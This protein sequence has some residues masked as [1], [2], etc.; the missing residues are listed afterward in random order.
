MENIIR[1]CCQSSHSECGVLVHVEDGMVTKIEGDPDHPV[2]R[3]YICVKAKAQPQLINHPD[4]LKYPM[5]QI[6]K[7]GNS[8]W[9]RISWDEALD[10]IAT[11]LTEIK[12]KNAPENIATIHGTGPRSSIPST[13]LLAHALGSPNVISTD[14]HICYAPSLVAE[15]CTVGTT[16]TMSIGPDYEY[17]NCVLVWGANPLASHGSRGRD[18]LEAKKRGAK[19]IVIDPRRTHLAKAADLWL[20]VRP[21][22]DAALAL[23]FIHTIIEEELYNTQFVDKWCYGFDKLRDHIKQYS[24]E[25]ISDIT[26]IPASKISETAR[27]YANTKPA[28]LY[29][30]VAVEHNLSSTQTNRAFCILTALTGN[31]DVKGGNIIADPIDGYIGGHALYA[32]GDSRFRLDH[33]VEEKRIGSIEYPLISGANRPGKAFT[34]VHAALAVDAMLTGNP[35]PIKALYCAGGNPIVNQQNSKKVW[36]ALKNLELL[37]VADFFMTPV[38][39]LADYVLPVTNWL[40]RDECCDSTYPNCISARQKAIEPLFECWDDLKIAIE[41]VKRIPWANKQFLPWNDVNEFNDFRIKGTGITFNEFKKKGYITGPL[42]YKKYIERGFN[43]PTKKVELFSTI[44]E[45]L[46][47]D[48]M[49]TFTEPPESPVSTPEL[50]KEYPF[51]LISGGRSIGYLHSE[52][53]QIPKLRSLVPDPLIELH[54]T[55]A[56]KAGIS[57]GCWVWVETP[58]V[59]GEKVQFKAKVTSD[60]DPRVVHVPHGWWFPEKPAPEHGCFDSNINVVLSDDPPREPICGSVNTRGT[61]CKIYPV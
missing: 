60:I 33:A 41:L 34:F 21:G 59:K 58:K 15:K 31:I 29:H 28:T 45:E 11:K 16:V 42:K 39:E 53:R 23:A 49:P 13:T 17:A 56:K 43:T 5:K 52:G 30:R 7:G 48:P 2:T 9:E 10:G 51:I 22:T 32:G 14:L 24:P 46:G 40:E 1:T 57:D 12:E 27:I 38:A 19:L 6:G 8:K 3:G 44:F 4:R 47:Y 50:V 35:Y 54:P 36:T 18:I 26:W 61:L 20:Q 37:I 25:K 55:T